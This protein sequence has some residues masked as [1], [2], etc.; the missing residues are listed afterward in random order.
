[1]KGN[2]RKNSAV[3][4]R[5]GEG[6][7]FRGRQRVREREA[8]TDEARLRRAGHFVSLP[9]ACAIVFSA[10]ATHRMFVVGLGSRQPFRRRNHL[11]ED[12]EMVARKRT[13]MQKHADYG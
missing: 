5:R 4:R 13:G 3:G 8:K 2:G 7:R 12:D 6:R 9:L 1:M 11:A 10:G